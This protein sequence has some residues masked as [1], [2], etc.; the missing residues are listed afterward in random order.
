MHG[1][2]QVCIYAL[3]QI[4]QR[5]YRWDPEMLPAFDPGRPGEG[6]LFDILPEHRI[7]ETQEDEGQVIKHSQP[8]LCSER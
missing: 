8:D 4:A 1:S 3:E 7:G 5:K 6:P 2:Y